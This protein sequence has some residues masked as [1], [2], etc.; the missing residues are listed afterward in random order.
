[1]SINYWYSNHHFII[2]DDCH[3]TVKLDRY[4]NR[5]LLYHSN[6]HFIIIVVCY[7]IAKVD[8]HCNHYVIT[9]RYYKYLC[10]QKDIL[11]RWQHLS[12]F[13][14]EIFCRLGI[15]LLNSCFGK[16]DHFSLIILD[17]YSITKLI[18]ENIIK[19]DC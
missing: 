3:S 16:L 6:H 4:C 13:F 1:M 14:Q 8:W 7:S 17:C 18:C 11:R 10:T 12:V 2:T 15:I 19:L 5:Y 9:M